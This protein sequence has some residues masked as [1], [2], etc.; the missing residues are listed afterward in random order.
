MVERVK[1]ELPTGEQ[2]RARV[3]ADVTAGRPLGANHRQRSLT[4]LGAC[5]QFA[6][7]FTMEHVPPWA[8]K[9]VDGRFCAPDREWYDNTVFFGEADYATSRRQCHSRNQTWPLGQWLDRPYVRK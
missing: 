2:M 8:E 7:R 3:A 4:F 1:H 9:S 5:T 6:N